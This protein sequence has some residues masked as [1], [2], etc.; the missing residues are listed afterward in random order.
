M[1]GSHVCVRARVRS[2][3]CVPDLSETLDALPV[4]LQL[5]IF[6]T[7]WHTHKHKHTHTRNLCVRERVRDTHTHV[8]VQSLIKK[9]REICF[10]SSDERC[11]CVSHISYTRQDACAFV[12][13][14]QVLCV[15][16]SCCYVWIVHYK[17]KWPWR[18]MVDVDQRLSV[19]QL[20]IHIYQASFYFIWSVRL[21][22]DVCSIESWSSFTQSSS[23]GLIFSRVHFHMT[24]V[25]VAALSH[26][27]CRVFSSLLHCIKFKTNNTLFTW[28]N[29][30]ICSVLHN[31]RQASKFV[32]CYSVLFQNISELPR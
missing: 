9:I 23:S 3:V 28:F 13:D 24:Y 20:D 16:A 15:F 21:S 25:F 12:M 32:L 1:Y 27:W 18:N 6:S 19:C 14:V 4:S 31:N 29:R 11:K 8:E 17:I 5:Q 7:Q 30:R 26:L 10:L 22:C 2:C